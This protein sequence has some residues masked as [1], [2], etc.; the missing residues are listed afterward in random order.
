MRIMRVDNRLATPRH[1]QT[2]GQVE[3]A[4]SIIKR[5]LIAAITADGDRWEEALPLATL[6]IN[7]NV[8]Q[9]TGTSPFQANFFREPRVPQT[10]AGSGVTPRG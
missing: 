2:S 3:R 1:A 10:L 9:A 6:A 8:Q 5:R 4:N 7:C